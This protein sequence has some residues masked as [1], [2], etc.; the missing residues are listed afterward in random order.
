MIIHYFLCYL[1]DFNFLHNWSILQIHLASF[2]PKVNNM[3]NKRHLEGSMMKNP[4]DYVDSIASEEPS[5][6]EAKTKIQ[7]QE[8]SGNDLALEW[9]TSDWSRCS[10]T[11]GENGTQIRSVECT[12]LRSPEDKQEIIPYQICV[13]SGLQPPVAIQSCGLSQCPSWT[14]QSWIPCP[15]AKCI[16]KRTGFQTRDVFCAVA[17]KTVDDKY[18][19]AVLRPRSTQK[20]RNRRCKGIWKT[21]L[22]SQVITKH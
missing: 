9:T 16:A 6:A 5:I 12:L 21:G 11:C 2:H 19:E 13:D 1:L 22:W 8:S 15:K 17:D 4:P 10:Q 3:W 18:C 14:A 20:C 7:E